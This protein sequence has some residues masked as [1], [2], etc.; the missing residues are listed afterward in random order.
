[1][2]DAQPTGLRLLRE[3]LCRCKVI[4]ILALIITSLVVTGF[5]WAKKEITVI[6]DGKTIKVSTFHNTPEE[7]LRQLDIHLNPKDEY[8]SSNPNM[9]NGTTIEVYR[10]VPVTVIFSNKTEEITTSKPTVGELAAS[11]GFSIDNS[12][13]VPDVNTKITPNMK[14]S[15]IAVTEKLVTKSLPIPPPVV[16]QPDGNM[17]KGEVAIVDNGQAGVKQVTMKLHFENGQQVSSA[18]VDEKVITAPVPKTVHVGTRDTVETSR[19]AMRFRAVHV[20]EATAYTP[21]DGSSSG[22]TAYGIPARRGVVAVD[23]RVIPLGTRVF[24]PDYGVA[25]AADTG[26]AIVGDRIDLC[27][28]SREEAYSFGRRAVKVYVIAD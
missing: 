5:I 10:A 27:V 18:V 22:I 17:E 2:S 26:S 14:I 7:I 19:G 15:I 6:A 12:K 16:N 23:P 4:S 21:F 13:T 9:D 3:V 20:M 25:L 11:L 24:V 8:R 28:D 1:M